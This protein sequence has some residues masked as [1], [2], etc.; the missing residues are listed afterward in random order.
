MNK[1]VHFDANDKSSATGFAVS[2]SR[3][4]K[5]TFAFRIISSSR[6]DYQN[7]RLNSTP[8]KKKKTKNS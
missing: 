3:F 4:A 1:V 2:V 7:V 5:I 6:C 8:S